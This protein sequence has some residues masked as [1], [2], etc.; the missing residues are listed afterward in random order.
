ML[1]NDPKGLNEGSSYRFRTAQSITQRRR[2]ELVSVRGI[3]ERGLRFRG[4]LAESSRSSNRTIDRFKKM[5]T[6]KNTKSQSKPLGKPRDVLD[7]PK[8]RDPIERQEQ[9]ENGS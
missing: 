1:K 6:I 4:A 3:L 9:F 7:F 5:P 8:R 2:P